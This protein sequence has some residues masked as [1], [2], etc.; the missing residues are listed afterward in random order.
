MVGDGAYL[1][2]THV[3]SATISSSSGTISLN[4]VLMCPNFQKSLLSVSKLC[5]DFP[6]GIFFDTNCVYLIDLLKE[7]VVAKGTRNKGLY[8]LKSEEFAA[9]FSDRQVATSEDL[10]HLR[11]G[12]ANFKILQQLKLS[13][14]ISV[15][16]SRSSL[17]CEPC[18]MGKSNKLQF[19]PSLSHVSQ[20]LE[21][22]HCDLWGPS[23]VVSSQGFR[24]YAV[25]VDDYT[26]FAWLYPLRYKSDF[27]QIFSAA[28]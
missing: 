9:H 10:W 27:F 15:N 12:H 4:E 3:G 24:F 8:L 11:L 14:E 19:F 23:P 5:E 28:F 1:P 26:R 2:I 6:C 16:R 25:L 13:R 17:V 7:K 20:P 18:Q 21:R 22:I